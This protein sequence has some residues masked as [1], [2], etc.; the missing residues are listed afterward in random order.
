GRPPDSDE[1][2]RKKAPLVFGAF[3]TW[4]RGWKVFLFAVEGSGGSKLTA[5]GDAPGGA[6][7]ERRC[8]RGGSVTFEQH[9]NHGA[10][11]FLDEGQF[12]FGRHIDTHEV[13]ELHLSGGDQVGERE[14]DVAFDCTF[15]VTSSVLGIGPF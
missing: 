4:V 7:S 5:T 15:Q 1:D 2:S 11:G 3:S 9:G 13:S 10:F 6:G 14:H 12:A 8:G